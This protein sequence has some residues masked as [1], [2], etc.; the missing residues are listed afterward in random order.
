[1]NES[2]LNGHTEPQC[3]WESYSVII[4]VKPE[5]CAVMNT[6]QIFITGGSWWPLPRS[7]AAVGL[8]K[9]SASQRESIL[10]PSFFYASAL[11]FPLFSRLCCFPLEIVLPDDGGN[12]TAD[13]RATIK[14]HTC[15]IAAP[16]TKTAGPKLRAG[17]TEVP[18]TGMPTR[19]IKT[20]LKPMAI[21]ANPLDASLCVA[22]KMTKRNSAV[23]TISKIKQ[24]NRE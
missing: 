5:T 13:N 21:Q 7:P 6:A 22:P 16:P 14:N 8:P 4:F 18:S 23:N 15:E 2:H 1:V 9:E 3:W 10:I 11:S 12:H 19:W 20:S 17:L 24:E